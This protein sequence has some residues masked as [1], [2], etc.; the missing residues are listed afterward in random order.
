MLNIDLIGI[1]ATLRLAS[2]ESVPDRKQKGAK[3]PGG[4]ISN[5]GPRY[6]KLVNVQRSYYYYYWQ[7]LCVAKLTFSPE[8]D[9]R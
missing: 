4:R 9:G 3:C 7:R 8:S 2:V 6:R 5:I 1:I